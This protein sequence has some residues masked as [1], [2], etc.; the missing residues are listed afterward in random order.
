MG[1]TKRNNVIILVSIPRPLIG[2]IIVAHIIIHIKKVI[3]IFV[4][5]NYKNSKCG[6]YMDADYKQ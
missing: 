3:F 4:T 6:L 1:Y 5:K 2:S